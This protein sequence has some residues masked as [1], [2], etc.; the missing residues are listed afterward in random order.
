MTIRTQIPVVAINRNGK[1]VLINQEDYDAEQHSLWEEEAAQQQQGGQEEPQEGGAETQAEAEEVAGEQTAADKE[2]E[3]AEPIYDQN[4]LSRMQ[5]KAI[6][7]LPIYQRLDEAD[8]ATK[9]SAVMAILALQ[10]AEAG[11]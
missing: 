11:N 1:R 4:E 2:T 5:H 10:E 3:E 6:K 8:K 7:A 9:R